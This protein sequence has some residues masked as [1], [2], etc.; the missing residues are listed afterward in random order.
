MNSNNSKSILK[1]MTQTPIVKKYNTI[2]KRFT[3][4]NLFVENKNTFATRFTTT[5]A[6]IRCCV[7]D[8]TVWLEKSNINLEIPHMCI[9]VWCFYRWDK[10]PGTSGVRSIR[11][12][13]GLLFL[14]MLNTA[15]IPCC[16][17]QLQAA[18]VICELVFWSMRNNRRHCDRQLQ[19]TLHS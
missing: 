14:T 12:S 8:L 5:S 6:T 13:S 15:L 18:I 9:D 2:L 7:V 11:L 17:S 19:L 3:L 10:S 1:K 16:I 4:S